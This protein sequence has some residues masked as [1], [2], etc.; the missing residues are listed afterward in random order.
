MNFSGTGNETVAD[1]ANSSWYNLVMVSNYSTL[2][3]CFTGNALALRVFTS[4]G[5]FDSQRHLLLKGLT[6]CDLMFVLIQALVSGLTDAIPALDP[7]DTVVYMIMTSLS[8][9]PVITSIMHLIFIGM[10]RCISIFLPLRYQ[11]IVVRR[12][13]FQLI[14]CSWIYSTV[15]SFSFLCATVYNPEIM[16]IIKRLWSIYIILCYII[17]VLFQLIIFTKI[18]VVVKKQRRTIQIMEQHVSGPS[19]TV[20]SF[21]STIRLIL[22]LTSFTVLWAPYIL[23][24]FLSS[25]NLVTVDN[26]DHHFRLRAIFVY[27]ANLNSF[28]NIFV[29]AVTDPTF[30]KTAKRLLRWKVI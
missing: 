15:A 7:T 9:I 10:D 13:I 27:I 14:V 1:G 16:G 6:V 2:V 23:F 12:R 20:S 25:F 29:Y 4:T 3:I 28:L 22:F 19:T 26:D 30:Y 18:I 21:K 17:I 11:Q 8:S 24:D 5:V